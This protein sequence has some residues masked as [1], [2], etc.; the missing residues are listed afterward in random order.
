[1]SNNVTPP[2][3]SLSYFICIFLRLFFQFLLTQI[4]T[5]QAFRIT[6]AWASSLWKHP[7]SLHKKFKYLSST[8]N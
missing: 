4:R 8:K 2:T 1:M 3:F 7:S 6:D 5:T